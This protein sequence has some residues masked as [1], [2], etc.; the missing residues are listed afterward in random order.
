MSGLERT[1]GGVVFRSRESQREWRLL[2]CHPSDWVQAI[3]PFFSVRVRELS[4]I[5]QRAPRWAEPRR[6]GAIHFR[7]RFRA[8]QCRRWSN[9]NNF[10]SKRRRKRVAQNVEATATP[11]FFN[12]S[13]YLALGLEQSQRPQRFFFAFSPNFCVQRDTT[14]KI[15]SRTTLPDLIYSPHSSLTMAHHFF[16]N[17][18]FRSWIH[19]NRLEITLIHFNEM[20]TLMKQRGCVTNK[21]KDH[22]FYVKTNVTLTVSNWI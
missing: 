6:I 14:E 17:E 19:F 15:L 18:I 9:N 8:G 3:S 12:V 20:K 22:L 21:T 10:L 13:Q 16:R 4:S 7:L 1:L 5:S 2:T 11:F